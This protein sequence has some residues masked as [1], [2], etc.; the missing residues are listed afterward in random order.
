MLVRN[1]D[2]SLRVC[3]DYRDL[4]N[5]TVKDAYPILNIDDLIYRLNKLEI[6]TT[7]DLVEG[8]N[9][10]EILEAFFSRGSLSRCLRGMFQSSNGRITAKVGEMPSGTSGGGVF[11]T[12]DHERKD[13]T[14]TIKS[15]KNCQFS[16]AYKFK[17][18]S[19]VFRP[20]WIFS[21][22]Y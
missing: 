10:V 12:R 17:T 9:Q 2:G 20:D 4:K 16:T 21:K 8:Y 18:A 22:F 19:R 3:I 5:A 15:A 1:K 6:A 11:R 14:I 13:Q 7:F